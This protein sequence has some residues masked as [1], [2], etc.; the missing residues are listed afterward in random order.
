MLN[1]AEKFNYIWIASN[2]TS[3]EQYAADYRCF[4]LKYKLIKLVESK[5]LYNWILHNL[6]V[7]VNLLKEELILHHKKRNILDQSRIV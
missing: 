1:Y 2:A 4:M 7:V 5:E 6:T 3:L